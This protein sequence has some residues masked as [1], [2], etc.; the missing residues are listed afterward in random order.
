MRQPERGSYLVVYRFMLDELGLSLVQAM[1]Y[2]RVYGMTY[3]T[4]RLFYESRATTAACLHLTERT[5]GKVFA[6]LVDRGLL[7]ECGRHR[8]G[9]GRFTRS[10]RVDE[11]AADAAA[12]RFVE[13]AECREGASGE[14]GSPEGTSGVGPPTGEGDSG[15]RAKRVRPMN[16]GETKT[17]K[18][19]KGRT[20]AEY[21]QR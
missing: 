8:L 4:D 13:R 1:V 2:A 6:E 21:D 15:G 14:A 3:Q 18:R 7:V 20:Y 12:A 11:K 17:E 19:I 9:S 5:L 10:Y 16:K